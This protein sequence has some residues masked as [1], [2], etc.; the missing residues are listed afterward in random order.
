MDEGTTAGR[1]KRLHRDEQAGRY[2]LE[3]D[4]IPVA[5]A[6]FRSLDGGVTVVPHTEVRRD[7]RGNGI[8][9]LLVGAVLDDLRHRGQRVV[10]A[11]WYVAEF[12]DENP[13]YGD[14]LAR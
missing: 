1:E 10:P 3:L 6:T 9:A 5:H 2:E 12:I 14:L 8:G 13:R 4:G 11:C 7:L